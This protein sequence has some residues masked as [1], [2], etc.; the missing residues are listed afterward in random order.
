[1]F[2]SPSHPLSTNLIK[3]EEFFFFFF[4]FSVNTGFGCVLLKRRDLKR[5]LTWTFVHVLCRPIK[6][7]AL[8][9]LLRA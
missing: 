6:T 4:F 1:M 5:G 2:C 7:S 3:K 9:N 8:L